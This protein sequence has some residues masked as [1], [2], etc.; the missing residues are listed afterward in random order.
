QGSSISG[1]ATRKGV[2]TGSIVSYIEQQVQQ[3]RAARGLQPINQQALDQVVNRAIT[4]HRHDDHHP[5]VPSSPPASR[6]QQ[7]AAPGPGATPQSSLDL[8]A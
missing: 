5:S 1:I 4:R 6:P 8:L 7:P 2:S 3:R